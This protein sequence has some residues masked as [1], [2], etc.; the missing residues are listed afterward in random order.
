MTKFPQLRVRTEF[1][2]SRLAYGPLPRV[3]ARLKELGCPAAGM[4][5]GGGGTWGHARFE[6]IMLE[7]GIEPMYGAEFVVKRGED[8]P[9]CWALGVTL[10]DLYRATSTPPATEEAFAAAKGL[11]RFCGA[12][13]SAP[14]SFDYID[15]SPRSPL[16]QRRAL[17]LHRQTG[18]PLALVS[19]N[20]CPAPE[21]MDLMRAVCDRTSTGVQWLAGA[22]ELRAAMPLLSDPEF[23]AAVRG[24]NEVAERL[25][26]ARIP[27]APLIYFE[28]DLA[29]LCAEGK[30]NRIA[31]G[32]IPDWTQEYEDRLKRELD[33]IK[34]KKF[35]SYF[36]MVS[37]LVRWAKERMLVGPARGS[38]A[39][40]L[41]CY[42]LRITEVDPIFHNL[43]FE[44]FVDINRND[45]PDIDIDFNDKKRDMVFDYLIE[46]Y[47]RDKV[48]RLGNIN[49]FKP[50]SV[51]M[52]LGK[53]LG[54]PMNDVYSVKNVL[55]E[56]ASADARYGKGLEDTLQNTVPGRK[57]AEKYPQAI[58][59][60]SIEGHATHTG[61][62]AAGVIVCNEPMTNFC[63]VN[64]EGVAQID[65]PDSEY[66]N[67]LKIDALGLRTLGIIEDSGCV[68]AD[69]L[70]ALKL[71]DPEVLR[72]FNEHKF[73]GVFQF[74]G[75]AQRQ[76]STMID[77]KSFKQLDH[78]TALSRPGPLG[79]GA[80][81]NYIRR[82][83]G[84]QEVTYRAEALAPYLKDT[85]GIVLYQEQVMAIVRDIGLFSW[86]KT[87][88][89]RKAMS[90]SKG[91]EYFD[92]MR[93][94]FIDG[95]NKNGIDEKIAS[96]IWGE[97][98]TFGAWGM[99]MAHTVSYAI[100]S[101]WCA[102]MKRYHPL[103]Y[104]AA[105]LRNSKD[106]AQVLDFLREMEAEGIGYIPIDPDLSESNWAAKDGK[107][108]GGLQNAVGFGPAKAA[109]YIEARNAGTLTEKAKAK[110]LSSQIKF[111]DLR[112]LHT[113]YG[114]M[115]SNPE[116]FGIRAGTRVK[117]MSELE[118]GQ[119]SVFI[120]FLVQKEQRDEHEERRIKRRNGRL[121]KGNTLFADMMM[122]DDSTSTPM[123]VRLDRFQWFEY[124]EMAMTH[125]IAGKDCFLIR[126]T[127]LRGF[128]MVKV[129][130]IKC[131]TQPG[132][133]NKEEKTADAS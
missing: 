71:N 43:L 8:K 109:A 62:H 81:D 89:V 111:S 4:V 13:L 91:G 48:G 65:K 68:T 121:F 3:A 99:N 98:Y 113:A 82:A 93:K 11:V 26:G 53:R 72:V 105:T 86:E 32:H 79:G 44:R 51:L 45:L 28:G 67:M 87:S 115:Y 61:V 55:L 7:A 104:A 122:V 49:T 18:K 129:N 120:G 23:D 50:N 126:G 130:K 95:A 34:L 94:D 90:A 33:L 10:P 46:K 76:I 70:Y 54:L 112:P 36:L 128:S 39:G 117:Q 96:E 114:E 124:G 119:E 110:L 131:L 75:A 125:S 19:D 127:K 17:N 118:D 47:G 52:Q 16:A 73:A 29:A 38:S 78:A 77:F 66:L 41:V 85:L 102:W 9:T 100:I 6:R 80:S 14:E 83:A 108:V 24:A 57:F 101:Y 59:L 5:N 42:V 12:A 97:I 31:L 2:F 107:L 20:F 56:Y 116:K 37:D 60:A 64:E 25:A 22:E 88:S 103:E 74:E 123:I 21:D 106:D 84:E 40:S 35:E 27:K 30:A 15:V 132:M 133:F 63:T 1:S 58:A 69:E 92:S